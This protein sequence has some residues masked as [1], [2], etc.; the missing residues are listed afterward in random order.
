MHRPST[1]VSGKVHVVLD[2]PEIVVARE[3]RGREHQGH[4]AEFAAPQFHD[5]MLNCL[6]ALRQEAPGVEQVDAEIR[7]NRLRHMGRID[8]EIDR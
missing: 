8:A 1:S 3:S 7:G 4:I 2:Q 5:V 6:V